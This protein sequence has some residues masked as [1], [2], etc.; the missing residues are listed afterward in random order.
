MGF[1]PHENGKIT[2]G[3]RSSLDE[4]NLCFF[5]ASRIFVWIRKSKFNVLLR[6]TNLQSS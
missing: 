2:M 3:V 1:E 5:L 4:T 6:L